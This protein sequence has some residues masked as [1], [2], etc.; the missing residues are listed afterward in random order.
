MQQNC[1]TVNW[2]KY[3]LIEVFRTIFGQDDRYKWDESEDRTKVHIR[4]RAAVKLTDT[5]D[6]PIIAISR[7][8]V[9]SQNRFIS[10]FHSMD[11]T[12]GQYNYTQLL[13]TTMT[14]NCLS[15]YGLVAEE[16][17]SIVWGAVTFNKRDIMAQGFMRLDAPAISE[18]QVIVSDSDY[19][20]TSVSVV[21][22]LTYIVYWSRTP[23]A[24]LLDDLTIRARNTNDVIWSTS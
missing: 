2:P 12:S 9:R 7:G 4:D 3:R 18:E 10:D 24:L 6:R 1:S 5:D 22:N 21:F 17:A 20:L 14:V 19:Q 16:L 8:S 15:P 11:M 23:R 13:E